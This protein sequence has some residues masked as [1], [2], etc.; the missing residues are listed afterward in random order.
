MKYKL[1]KLR[2]LQLLENFNLRNLRLENHTAR[3]SYD[4]TNL[5]HLEKLQ[6]LETYNS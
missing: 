4:L 6:L 2:N 5:Q 3:E 1:E